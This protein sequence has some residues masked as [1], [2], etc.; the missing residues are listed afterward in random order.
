VSTKSGQLQIFY[1]VLSK[2]YAETIAREWNT[3]DEAPGFAG[4]VTHFEVDDEHAKRYPVRVAGSAAHRELWVPA[5]ELASFNDHIL[6]AI[7]VV[8]AFTGPGFVGTIDPE[9]MLPKDLK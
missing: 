2:E 9:T 4:F 8:S 7:A 6:G 1:P 3:R 5:E